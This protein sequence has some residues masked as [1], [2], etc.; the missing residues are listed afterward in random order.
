MALKA[1]FIFVAPGADPDKDRS[2]VATPEVELTV[3][4]V[5]DY[6]SAEKVAAALVAAGIVAIELCGGFGHAGTARIAKAVE[7]KA[8]VGVVRFDNH[9][10]LDGK[11]GDSMF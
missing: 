6:A 3:V 7:G 2:V 8:A 1:A 10:G 11:S 5:S 9:P 4:G